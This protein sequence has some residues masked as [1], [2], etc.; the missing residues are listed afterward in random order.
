M[1]KHHDSCPRPVRTTILT[2][3]QLRASQARISLLSQNRDQVFLVLLDESVAFGSLVLREI[4]AHVVQSGGDLVFCGVARKVLGG[5]R[6]N[7]LA[8]VALEVSYDK[9]SCGLG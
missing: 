7:L 9:R 6:D 3:S 4:R 8:E 2:C 1:V 5:G